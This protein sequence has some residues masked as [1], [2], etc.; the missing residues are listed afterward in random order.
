MG[1]SVVYPI[2]DPPFFPTKKRPFVQGIKMMTKQGV[3]TDTLVAPFDLEFVNVAIWHSDYNEDDY[4][5][6]YVNG[7]QIVSKCFIKEDIG[8]GIYWG[9]AHPVKKGQAITLDYVNTGKDK[10]VK[11]NYQFLK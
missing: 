5:D 6:L 8:E 9:V 3:T 2:L 4:W 1:V 7:E 10:I 11:F